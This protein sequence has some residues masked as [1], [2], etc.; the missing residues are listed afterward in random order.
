MAVGGA[1]SSTLFSLGQYASAFHEGGRVAAAVAYGSNEQNTYTTQTDRHVLG[2]ASIG[3]TWET[4][5][6][7]YG[8]NARAGA[9]DVSANFTVEQ[10]S[11][12]V[13]LG[14][15]A[16][17]QQIELEGLPGLQIDALHSGA[18]AGASMVIAHANLQPG[19][20]TVVQH[21]AA[22]TQAADR[23]TMADLIAVFVFGSKRP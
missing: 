6:A 8:S 2:G 7:F 17:Q 20:Y 3:G 12:V 9:S 10:D 4:F 1:G 14:L 13:V 16:S 11:L 21:S 15:A 18:A 5:R 19:T 23:D 22:L